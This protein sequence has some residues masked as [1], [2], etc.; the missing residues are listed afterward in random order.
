MNSWV[1]VLGA[2]ALAGCAG[3]GGNKVCVVNSD[4]NTDEVCVGVPQLP[5]GTCQKVDGAARADG[6]RADGGARTDGGTALDGGAAADGGTATDGGT[7]ADGGGALDGG[8]AAD[9][10]GACPSPGGAASD[11]E[12]LTQ[13]CNDTLAGAEILTIGT[14]V[15][16]TIG[17][18][19]AAT[20]ANDLD[21][22]KVDLVAGDLVR[23]TATPASGS[24]LQP[25]I[26]ILG[27]TGSVKRASTATSGAAG[28]DYFVETTGTYYV[29]VGDVRNDADVPANVGGASFGYTLTSSRINLSSVSESSLPVS[30]SSSFGTSGE[31]Q[32]PVVRFTATAGTVVTGETTA[33]RLMPT[34]GNAD[35]IIHLVDLTGSTPAIVDTNDDID[36][37]DGNYDSLLTVTI[38]TTGSYAF[39]IDYLGFLEEPPMPAFQFSLTSSGGGGGSG[40]QIQAMRDAA[41]NAVDGGT[42]TVSLAVTDA[43]VTY[44]KPL[45]S[46]ASTTNDPAG[47]FV[48]S[49]AGPAIFVAIDPATLSPSPA[50]GDTV[51]FIATTVGKNN[52][53]RQVTALS[54]YSRAA[55]G[56]TLSPFSTS[57]NN[58]D[59]TMA[60]NV[61]A[62]ESRLV[63]FA[64]TINASFGAAGTSYSSGELA[65]TGT[66][67][68]GNALK[69]RM[70]TTLRDTFDYVATCSVTSVGNG[71]PLWRFTSGSTNQA[72]PSVWSN[73]E[74]SVA[75]PMPKVLSAA[76]TANTTVVVTFDRNIEGSSVLANGSQFTF[77][78]G[79]STL[80]A[81]AAAVSGTNAKQ[82]IVTTG[83]QT[84]AAAYTVNVATTVMD[85]LNNTLNPSNVSANFTGFAC[86][87]AKVVIS[88]VYGGGGNASAPFTHD[89]VELHNRSN[90][91]V[92]VSTWAVSTASSTGTS[93]TKTNLSGMIGAGGYY[94]V[95]MAAGTSCDGGPCGSPLP[96]AEATGSSNMSAS[97]TKVALAS[98]QTALPA[99]ACPL[100]A[101]GGVAEIVDF[102]GVGTANCSEG[103]T[104]A[105]HSNTTSSTRTG[106]GCDDTNN[107]SADFSTPAPAPRNASTTAVT[108]ACQGN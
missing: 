47:F 88:Q 15:N 1:A 79:P 81:S 27:S 107:N 5:A 51:A 53:I 40:A 59:F 96:T 12:S 102:V 67:T 25:V 29:A 20:D 13:R 63:T 87:T 58:T 19:D 39:V 16:G 82:V 18:Y 45:V 37:L 101:D 8:G 36:F 105:A 69:L 33:V 46:G 26:G 50:P 94:L 54:G 66:P 86:T 62:F 93:W 52:G 70:P 95:Q 24:M 75:C 97:G 90:A 49:S 42:S 103:T 35:T 56:T 74:I 17:T 78:G 10:G 104:A 99:V 14:P 48:A 92:D 31:I 32:I 38:P 68:P 106:D 77:T 65:T 73:T 21:L 64:G 83:A 23:F 30:L 91:P 80:V 61:D 22:Y 100:T 3:S 89:F 55:T 84:G 72:Q 34:A 6:G 9:G 28:R 44:V 98:T 4:C 71:V 108:C 11:N 76:A 57:I 43:V 41:D 60:A 2:A 7:A 85:N